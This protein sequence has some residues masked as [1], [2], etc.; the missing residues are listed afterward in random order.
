MGFRRGLDRGLNDGAEASGGIIGF[1]LPIAVVVF[2]VV[3]LAA[4]WNGC[5][6]KKRAATC[7]DYSY[8]VG[9]LDKSDFTCG[10]FPAMKRRIEKR[11]VKSDIVHCSCTEASFP[12]AER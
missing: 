8:E 10:R 4:W 11:W 9:I 5:F 6:N 2:I 7:T 12:K 1:F 3:G